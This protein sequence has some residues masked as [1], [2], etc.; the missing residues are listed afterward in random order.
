[1]PHAVASESER[2]IRE[3]R[4]KRKRF[5]F[6]RIRALPLCL[7]SRFISWP[8]DTHSRIALQMLEL[9]VH[10]QRGKCPT[11]SDSV[12]ADDDGRKKHTHFSVNCLQFFFSA[13]V[14]S[15]AH[16]RRP[17][18]FMSEINVIRFAI[19]F[20]SSFPAQMRR[21]NEHASEERERRRY[22]HHTMRGSQVCR[23]GPRQPLS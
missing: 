2:N 1:M 23:R 16:H 14:S 8:K 3:N 11:A 9:F 15:R 17:L 7:A 21:Y 5:T 20:S 22:H 10:E 4:S 19:F 13:S 6:C 18:S 12:G